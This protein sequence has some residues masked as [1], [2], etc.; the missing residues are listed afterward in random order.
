MISNMPS[1]STTHTPDLTR[2]R[3]LA[4]LRRILDQYLLGAADQSD[5]EE[6]TVIQDA[7]AR[8]TPEE[9][10]RFIKR[11]TPPPKETSIEPGDRTFITLPA[12]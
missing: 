4:R 2:L 12:D 7:M 5:N 10:K 3:R 6:L 11:I 1:H 9:R 8:L